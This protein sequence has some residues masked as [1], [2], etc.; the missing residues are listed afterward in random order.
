VRLGFVLTFPEVRIMTHVGTA[1]FCLVAFASLCFLAGGLV[2]AMFISFLFL[3]H[4]FEIEVGLIFVLV[5]RPRAVW[6]VCLFVPAVL[7]EVPVV[8]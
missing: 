7:V 2:R 3:V 5:E 4:V 1:S 6:L 8:L